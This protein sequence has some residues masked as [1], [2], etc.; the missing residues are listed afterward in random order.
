MAELE[1]PQRL[2]IMLNDEELAALENWR[3]EK[4]MPSRSAAVRELLRRGLAAEGFLTAEAGIKSQDFG[5]VLSSAR[6]NGDA[7]NSA[8]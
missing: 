5:V 2:Q 3:F 4:R 7:E 8:D 1:R 6:A